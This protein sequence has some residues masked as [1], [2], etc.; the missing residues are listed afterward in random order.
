MDNQISFGLIIIEE[1]FK[2]CNASVYTTELFEEA[3]IDWVASNDQPFTE[4]ETEKF[5]RLSSHSGLCGA[6]YR[7]HDLSV[8]KIKQKNADVMIFKNLVI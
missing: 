8:A 2:K 6:L 4:I 1:S 5:R 3:L 7:A